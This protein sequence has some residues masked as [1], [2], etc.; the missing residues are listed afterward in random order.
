MFID[1]TTLFSLPYEDQEDG[2]SL[3]EL[4][5]VIVIIGILSAIAVGA[6][7]NQRKKAEDA[8][9]KSDLRTIANEYVTWSMDNDNEAF[10]GQPDVSNTLLAVGDKAEH[11]LEHPEWNTIEGFPDVNVSKNT[12]IEVVV[13]ASETVTWTEV[14][15]A[16]EFCLIGSSQ[17]SSYDYLPGSGIHADYD[18]YLFFD[19]QLGG[20]RI[21][22][23]LIKAEQGGQEYSC[24]GSTLRHMQA[25]GL[26]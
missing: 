9:L 20:V 5:V 10:A 11:M 8:A 17:A 15:Q 26:A 25:I 19:S 18:K 23:D 14:F 4:L 2:F 21:M 16:G 22:D 24:K 6:F 1:S 3:V 12:V 7:M 13:N